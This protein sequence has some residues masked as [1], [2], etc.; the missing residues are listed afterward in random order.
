MAAAPDGPCP[1]G[2]RPP[3]PCHRAAPGPVLPRTRRR[4][5]PQLQ[6]SPAGAL[7]QGRGHWVP[8]RAGQGSAGQMRRAR[9]GTPRPPPHCSPLWETPW[10]SPGAPG[11]G[12]VGPRTAGW[13]GTQRRQ[14]GRRSGPP[15]HPRRCGPATGPGPRLRRLP[16]QPLRPLRPGLREQQERRGQPGLPA[17]PAPRG[18]AWGG[19]WAPGFRPGAAQIPDQSRGPRCA[20]P[21]C[22]G[23]LPRSPSR[24]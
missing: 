12:C 3:C 24:T 18:R 8:P 7:C 9:A 17:P 19:P 4:P 5:Q 6:R 1:H 20:C 10:G 14:A 15:S 2:P 16:R 23:T 22:C 11:P 21:A 13:T